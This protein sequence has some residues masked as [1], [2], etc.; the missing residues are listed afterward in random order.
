MCLGRVT[1]TRIEKVNLSL[2]TRFLGG[3]WFFLMRWK[4]SEMISSEFFSGA[5]SQFDHKIE[6]KRERERERFPLI[7]SQ[8]LFSVFGP[9]LF[10]YCVPPPEGEKSSG[11][12]IF[13]M[14]PVPLTTRHRSLDI[15]ADVHDHMHWT[16]TF[17]IF[18]LCSF[19][20]RSCW[21]RSLWSS[22][23]WTWSM[24]LGEGSTPTPDRRQQRDFPNLHLLFSFLDRKKY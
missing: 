6:R 20:W 7:F 24:S 21:L 19:V 8:L 22:P 17:G 2:R 5:S 15:S 11:Q 3:R 10:V 13:G 4:F 14:K 16:W 9:C 12:E 1:S 23:T 18:G